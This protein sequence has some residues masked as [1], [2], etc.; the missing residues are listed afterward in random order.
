MCEDEFN[1][2]VAEAGEAG[3]ANAAKKVCDMSEISNDARFC[4][5]VNLESVVKVMIDISVY[6]SSWG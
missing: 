2:F 3:E 4:D 5:F 6:K 1:E